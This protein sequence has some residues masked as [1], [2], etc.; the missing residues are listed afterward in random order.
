[1]APKTIGTVGEHFAAAGGQQACGIVGDRGVGPRGAEQPVRCVRTDHQPPSHPLGIDVGDH[2]DHRNRP[3]PGDVLGD[4]AQLRKSS[5]RYRLDEDVE[6]AATGEPD[7]EGVVVT[8]AVAL[9]PRLSVAHNVIGEFIYRTL[10]TAARHRPAHLAVR[11]H[12]HRRSR[13]SRG[14]LEGANDGA[15]TCGF[16]RFPDSHQLAQHLTH[17]TQRRLNS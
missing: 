1:M 3:M 6:D 5:S 12:H 2:C 13:R 11:R 17:A 15:E 7:G 10:D 9:Q 8:D 16:A 4:G 14:R